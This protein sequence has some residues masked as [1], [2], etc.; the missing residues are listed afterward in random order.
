MFP[1][2]KFYT[3]RY[4]KNNQS[5]NPCRGDFWRGAGSPARRCHGPGTFKPEQRELGAH[6]ETTGVPWLGQMCRDTSKVG[7]GELLPTLP[8]P[9]QLQQGTG[10]QRHYGQS[11]TA[12]FPWPHELRGALHARVRV[13]FPHEILLARLL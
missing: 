3:N 5:A 11:I 7:L 2:I 9:G 1:Q 8:V 4:L 10:K 6:R 12:P 13:G